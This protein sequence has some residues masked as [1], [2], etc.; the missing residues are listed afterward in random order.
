[1]LEHGTLANEVHIL[2]R[3]RVATQI[4]NE[5]AKPVP[6]PRSQ[7]DPA[8]SWNSSFRRGFEKHFRYRWSNSQARKAKAVFVFRPEVRV[9][10]FLFYL[11]V[12]Q[13]REAPF[14]SQSVRKFL[15]SVA[16]LIGASLPRRYAPVA[17]LSAPIALLFVPHAPMKSSAANDDPAI[18]VIVSITTSSVKKPTINA[19]DFVKPSK[20]D[21]KQC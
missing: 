5:R 10:E 18:F 7:Y 15:A 21:I 4:C 17:L 11:D 20:K 2:L 19:C 13:S 3:K 14:R 8:T 16:G 9:Q 12:A 6:L 1:M